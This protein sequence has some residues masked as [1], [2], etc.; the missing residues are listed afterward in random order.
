[1]ITIFNSKSVYIGY[2]LNKF[3]EIRNYL[4]A[5]RIRYK[6]KVKNRLGQWE[7]RGTRRGSMGSFGTPPELMYE[8]EILVHEKDYD[9]VRL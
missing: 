1:M 3:N 8:Y 9:K 4:D 5:N 2:D 7:G 6:Y